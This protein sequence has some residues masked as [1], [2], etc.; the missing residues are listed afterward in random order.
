MNS[1][2]SYLIEMAAPTKEVF[3]KC[4]RPHLGN[5]NRDFK[6]GTHCDRF[7]TRYRASAASSRLGARRHADSVRRDLSP[8]AF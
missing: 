1:E 5:L 2:K 6:R 7:L 3:R 8:D 4:T